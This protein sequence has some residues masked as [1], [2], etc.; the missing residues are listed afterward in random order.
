MADNVLVAQIS[1][2]RAK[3]IG[4]RQKSNYHYDFFMLSHLQKI[5]MRP[6]CLFRPEGVA[7]MLVRDLV[8]MLALPTKV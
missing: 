3:A 8:G 6:K 1:T 5:A 2:A 4:N 7:L